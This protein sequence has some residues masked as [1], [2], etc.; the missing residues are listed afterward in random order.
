MS[1]FLVIRNH[2]QKA[3]LGSYHDDIEE[4]KAPYKKIKTLN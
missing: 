4:E 2:R 1:P 3:L